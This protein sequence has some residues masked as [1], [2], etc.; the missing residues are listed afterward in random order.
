M[1]VTLAV[2]KTNFF[3]V[4]RTVGAYQELLILLS[5]CSVAYNSTFDPINSV[6]TNSALKCLDFSSFVS[7]WPFVSI[8]IKKRPRWVH[9]EFFVC[10]AAW[11]NTEKGNSFLTHSD[12]SNLFMGNDKGTQGSRSKCRF[13]STWQ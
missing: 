12:I 8:S 9:F 2:Q 4:K 6:M 10:F 1:H 3:S 7:S 13:R 11:S 5:I